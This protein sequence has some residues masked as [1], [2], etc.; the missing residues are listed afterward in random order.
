MITLALFRLAAIALGLQAVALPAMAQGAAAAPASSPPGP[1][2]VFIAKKI[3]TMDPGWPE[4]TAVAV[5]DGKILSVGSLDDLQPWLKSAPHK[6]DRTFASKILLPGFIEPHG[7]PILASTTYNLPLLTYLPTDNPYGK[8]FPGVK[9]Q[10]AVADALR[11]YVA[12]AKSPDETVLA[13]GYDVIAMGGKHLDKTQLDQISTTQPILIWD[14]SEHYVYANSAALKKYKINKEDIAK[15]GVGAGADGEPN[16]QFLGVTALR[17]IMQEPLNDLLQPAVAYKNVRYLMDLSRKNG[18]TTTSDLTFGNINLEMEQ[19]VNN[20][21]FND[22]A[23]PMRVVQV[24]DTTAFAA[25]KGDQAVAFVL[26]L[27]KG[28]TDRIILNGAKVFADD[29]Y[30]SHSMRMANPGYID[31]SKG[32]WVTAPDKM[33]VAWLPWWTSGLQ[34]HA[35]SN[36]DEAN[37]ATLKALAELMNAHPRVD[38]RFTLEHFGISSPDQIYKV[39]AL[40]AFVGANPYFLYNRADFSVPYIGERARINPR[41]KSMVDAGVLT[42]LHSDS[43]VG[44]PKPLEMAWIA[45]NRISRAG[46]V[47][48]PAERVSVDQAMRM[49]TINAA[50]MLGVDDRVGSI[51]PGKFADFAVLDQDPYAVPKVQIKDIAVWGTVSGGRVFPASEIRQ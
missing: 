32:V 46:K 21:Y 15:S 39:K 17:R 10:A 48:G 1:I 34:M 18:I 11:K 14:A 28:N 31:S 5:R 47:D 8:D 16:G 35:H 23:S 20:K 12:L 51:V 3:I 26:G 9:T 27:T 6:I 38:H 13:W 40:G 37:T 49:V 30:L 24:A 22:P 43:P 41:L 4:A 45:I 19:F 50:V 2:T 29:A 25:L 36:G 42:A 7:H 44:P 33:A